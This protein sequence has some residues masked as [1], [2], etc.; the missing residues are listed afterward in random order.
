MKLSGT[1]YRDRARLQSRG[2]DAPSVSPVLP[3]LL[4]ETMR[5]RDRPDEVME[6]ED[7]TTSLP[8]RLGLSEVVRTQIQ[9]FESEVR[10]RRPQV[11][12]QVEDLIRLVIRRPD[13]EEIFADAGRNVARRYYGERSSWLRWL[14]GFLPRALAL[15]AAQRAGRRMFSELVG[16]TPYWISRRPVSLRI[17]STL[18]ARADPGGAACAFYAGAFAELLELYTG[19][20]YRV[21]H[22]HCKTRKAGGVCEWTTEIS[23]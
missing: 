4:L 6:D 16:P 18:T 19:R 9:R 17:D 3:L 20:Q 21:S 8:R 14:L 7:I 13:A 10:Q 12:S 23:A 11:P 5:D 1:P 15:I 22:L 2:P